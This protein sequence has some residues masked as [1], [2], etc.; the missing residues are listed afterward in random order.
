LM[1]GEGAMRAASLQ[2]KSIRRRRPGADFPY[3]ANPSAAAPAVGTRPAS[4]LMDEPAARPTP[5]LR[6]RH[7]SAPTYAALWH[8]PKGTS[9]PV[10]AGSEQHQQRSS[11]RSR[12][13]QCRCSGHLRRGRQ[14]AAMC[15]RRS[16]RHTPCAARSV[17]GLEG[18]PSPVSDKGSSPRS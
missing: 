16:R 4:A 14:T 5:A 13:L 7:A 8:S 10:A 17:L 3:R 2:R 11:G 12:L 1:I 18:G 9:E 15:G 6:R